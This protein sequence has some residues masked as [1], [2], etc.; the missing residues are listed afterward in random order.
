MVECVE[1]LRSELHIQFLPENRSHLGNRQIQIGATRS[2][3]GI[4]GQRAIGSQ[5]RIRHRGRVSWVSST[6][7]CSRVEPEIPCPRQTGT[8]V[9]KRW[10]SSWISQ[11]YRSAAS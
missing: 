6:G 3:E 1:E 5:R 10:I 7:D 11:G 4:S 2:T 9:N 8:R